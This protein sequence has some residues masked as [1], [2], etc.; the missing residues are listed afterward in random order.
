LRQASPAPSDPWKSKVLWYLSQPLDRLLCPAGWGCRHLE[1]QNRLLVL[2]V[3]Q[4]EVIAKLRDGS[5]DKSLLAAVQG[6]FLAI[7]RLRSANLRETGLI[8]AIL[9]ASDLS[10]AYMHGIDL[11]G[12]ALIGT[13]LHGA[14]VTSADLRNAY[15]DGADLRGANLSNSD[16]SGADLRSADLRGAVYDHCT[17]FPADFDPQS[18]AMTYQQTECGMP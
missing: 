9:S 7:R 5:G 1:V 11:R 10:Y 6:E 15:F 3:W 8:A 4:P 2:H 17:R 18:R 13:D 12:A 16:L 14:V